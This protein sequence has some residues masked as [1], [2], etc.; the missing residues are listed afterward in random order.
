MSTD[1][2]VLASRLADGCFHDLERTAT[3]MVELVAPFCESPIEISL[4]A[5]MLLR[6]ALHRSEYDR[7]RPWLRFSDTRPDD[8]LAAR[9]FPQFVWRSYR[10]DWVLKIPRVTPTDLIFIE[11]DGHDYHERTKEQA[12][13][14]RQKDREIQGAG[15][16]ILRFTG[17]EIYAD[18]SGC[19]DQIFSFAAARLPARKS[20]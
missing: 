1:R 13:R 20:A 19:V 17:S 16:P 5:A 12:A 11:C 10:I 2:R 6:N 15:I 18:A 3:R 14:D 9:L 8:E 4:G 7:D